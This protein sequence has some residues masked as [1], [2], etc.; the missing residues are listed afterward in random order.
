MST[1]QAASPVDIA[2]IE[3]VVQGNE[4][5]FET[6]LDQFQ[7]KVYRT[8]FGMM[9]N[10]ED[11]NDVTQEVFIKVF[12]KIHQ[13]KEPAVFSSWL[14]RMTL[15]TAKTALMRRKIRSCLSLDL[16]SEPQT[17][18]EEPQIDPLDRDVEFAP[19]N[20]ALQ[21]L[22]RAS[23]EILVLREINDF[24]YE[25]LSATLGCAIGTVKSRLNRAKAKLKALL[26]SL[27]EGDS[28]VDLIS[29]TISA[30]LA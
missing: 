3:Q 13:L 9:G 29:D 15:N 17:E 25:E 11:A 12:R 24:S 18:I 16:F 30:P 8:A 19:L 1:F 10:A 21:K 6:L 22:D 2:L 26:L 20:Q 7:H 28:H 27:Q 5:A 4:P 14:Y 23:R